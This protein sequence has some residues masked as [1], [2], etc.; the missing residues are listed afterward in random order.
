MQQLNINY[1]TD[2]SHGWLAVNR[3]SLTELGIADKITACSYVK[4][5]VVYL[6]EDGDAGSYMRAYE[7]KYGIKPNLV[8]IDDGDYS[9]IREYKSYNFY[10]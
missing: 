1:H 5:N 2:G 3:D 9:P 10:K 8:H 4:G 6:E 7:Q